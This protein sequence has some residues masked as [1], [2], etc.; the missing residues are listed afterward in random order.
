MLTSLVGD[1]AKCQQDQNPAS[2][3]QVFTDASNYIQQPH[4]R[5][6]RDIKINCRTRLIFPLG[7]HYK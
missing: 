7:Y 4:C 1:M 6:H 2:A 5:L 3:A